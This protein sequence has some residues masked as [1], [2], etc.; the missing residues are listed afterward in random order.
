MVATDKIQVCLQNEAVV[1]TSPM[2][3]M[4]TEPGRIQLPSGKHL[5]PIC[6]F[7]LWWR[8]PSICQLLPLGWV[9][10]LCYRFRLLHLSIIPSTSNPKK[11]SLKKKNLWRDLPCLRRT[12]KAVMI[13]V[14]WNHNWARG[15]QDKEADVILQNF[16]PA[17]SLWQASA[18][19][20]AARAR[21]CGTET[22]NVSGMGRAWEWSLQTVALETGV[23]C[24]AQIRTLLSSD[25]LHQRK[26]RL[27]ARP[28]QGR[29]MPVCLLGP[30]VHESVL[31]F[32][33]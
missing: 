5:H 23:P 27:V 10:I 16:S 33:G 26:Y 12:R 22:R 2:I 9:K 13:S 32:R 1:C 21:L 30:L 15:N 25:L 20:A 8:S 29:K 17:G 3:Y 24:E 28:F 18:L 14:E 11:Y 6:S 7:A 4:L 31:S 19:G